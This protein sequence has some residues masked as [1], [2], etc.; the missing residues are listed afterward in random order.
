[1]KKRILS[2]VVCMLLLGLVIAPAAYA[3]TLRYGD[4]GSQVTQ[5]QVRLANLGYYTAKVDGKFGFST[6]QAV[7]GF[8]NI[9][10]LKVDGIIGEVTNARLFSADA[11]DKNSKAA[12]PAGYQRIAYGAEGPAVKTVQGVLRNLGYYFDD[13]E[14]KFGYST[15]QAVKAFQNNN[16]SAVDGVVG[17]LTWAKLMSGS[18][19]PIA[20][21]NPVPAPVPAPVPGGVP[22]RV[23]FG[24]NNG[25][26][27]Q[28]QTALWNLGFDPG[29][30]DGKFG[31]TTFEA[32]KAF[33]R[34]N[35]LKADGIV[36]PKTW[37]VL[38]GTAPIAAGQQPAKSSVHLKYGDK[39]SAVKN[40]QQRLA[41]LGYQV[42]TIDG[43]F[44]WET[45]LAVH[46]FQ[47]TNGLPV[48]SIVGDD[49]WMTM[50]GPRAMGP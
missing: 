4:R 12:P 27:T 33:Q 5:A 9:N 21:V 17:P 46:Q 34:A 20:P 15:F 42:A 18:G 10:G 3:S 7:L 39:G 8:Q 6:Y 31:F 50:F 13:V 22:N 16:S 26:V 43:D 2:A 47:K 24:H 38:F 23:Q 28:V 40:V 35:N 41:D 37:N 36:G 11:L 32:V 30:I 49:T 45:Y 1:M 14:G 19:A 44:G 29:K 25:Y 48:D